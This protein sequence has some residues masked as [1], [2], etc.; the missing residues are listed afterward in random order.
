MTRDRLVLVFAV[1]SLATSLATTFALVLVACSSPPPVNNEPVADAGAPDGAACVLTTDCVPGLLC[2]YPI[3]AGCAA[4]G[5]CVPEYLTCPV[6]GPI[7]C[8]CDGVTPVGL[9]CIY[10]P[11]YAAVPVPGTTPGCMPEFDALFE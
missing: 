3:E 7:V 5:V 1:G 2:G 8:G 4:Q 11:G 6:D 9:A 10:G